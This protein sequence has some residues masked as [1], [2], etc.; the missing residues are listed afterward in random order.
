VLP[1]LGGIARRG[2][3]T[4]RSSIGFGEHSNLNLNASKL[5]GARRLA[6]RRRPFAVLEKSRYPNPSSTNERP[7]DGEMETRFAEFADAHSGPGT[8]GPAQAPEVSGCALHDAIKLWG[9]PMPSRSIASGSVIGPP[10]TSS[11]ACSFPST[12]IT[13]TRRCEQPPA[14][15]PV[16]LAFHERPRP[17]RENSRAAPARPTGSRA[18]AVGE[19]P[20]PTSSPP[21][22]PGPP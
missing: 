1:D 22:P 17:P 16:A 20:V 21:L 15:H 13:S 5:A 11:W 12:S 14:E 7:Q 6:D 8:A 3:A 10:G 9:F 18:A 4:A 19:I 2:R